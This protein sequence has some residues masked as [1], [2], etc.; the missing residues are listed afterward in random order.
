MFKTIKRIYNE[1]K[2]SRTFS[3]A[4]EPPAEDC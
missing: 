1:L 2:D 4:T 3:Q